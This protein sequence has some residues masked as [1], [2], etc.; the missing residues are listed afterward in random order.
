MNSVKLQ[1]SD[2]YKEIKSM[3]DLLCQF[4]D[5][6]KFESASEL[7]FQSVKPPCSRC[8]KAS[9]HHEALQNALL[10]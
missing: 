9:L 5:I 10:H 7:L 2:P 3:D 8:P 1:D 6:A 4:Q